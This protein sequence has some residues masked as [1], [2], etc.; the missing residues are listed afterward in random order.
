MIPRS[1][2]DSHVIATIVEWATRLPKWRARAGVA[3]LIA[4]VASLDYLTGRSVSL[5]G[6]YLLTI[7]FAAWTLGERIGFAAAMLCML[8]A[9]A[10]NGFGDGHALSDTI[11][12]VWA[13][14]WNIGMRTFSNAVVV[15]VVG[16]FRHC[17]DQ[18]RTLAR[19]DPLTGLLNKRAFFDQAKA[20]LAFAKRH[21]RAAVLAYVDL[22]GFKAVNDRFGHAAGDA[23]LRGFA[24]AATG[25]L[26]PYDLAGRIGGDEF[27]FLLSAPAGGAGLGIAERIHANLSACLDHSPCLVTCSTGAIVIEAPDGADGEALARLA[28]S[29]MYDVKRAGKDAVRVATVA[30]MDVAPRAGPCDD[31]ALAGF[32]ARIGTVAGQR[33][34]DAA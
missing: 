20:S 4:V 14:V 29:L 30:T 27:V 33:H 11:L 15:L 24:E 18:E 22:D 9:L 5:N 19:L 10:C 32:V 16:S 7:C 34:R 8:L 17:F 6:L 3:G 2:S 12:P 13:R 28:D 31:G 21:H 26:R 23:V 25:T 1:R